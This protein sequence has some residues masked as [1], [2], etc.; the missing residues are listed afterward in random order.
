[1]RKN[2]LM[3]KFKNFT[4]SNWIDWL[5]DMIHVTSGSYQYMD[6][7]SN[8]FNA[9]HFLINNK[10]NPKQ[11]NIALVTVINKTHKIASY[12]FELYQL[13]DFT[14]YSKPESEIAVL[15]RLLFSNE[16][17]GLEY[18]NK[19]LHDVLINAL[20]T[21][22]NIDHIKF[23]NLF[24]KGL[25]TIVSPS[26]ILAALRYYSKQYQRKGYYY[27]IEEVFKVYE[28]HP[29]YYE[30]VDNVVYS[31]IEMTESVAN[32]DEVFYWIAEKMPVWEEMSPNCLKALVG[33]SRD[34]LH[35][36]NIELKSFPYARLLSTVFNCT[37]IDDNNTPD[38]NDIESLITA[39]TDKKIDTNST[40]IVTF[41]SKILI[42]LI[43]IDEVYLEQLDE[44][45]GKI[46]RYSKI[47]KEQ[48]Y[49]VIALNNRVRLRVSNMVAKDRKLRVA[50]S[51]RLKKVIN[52]K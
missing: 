19:S 10:I 22:V 43:Y 37:V 32:Y 5:D 21:F 26:F 15:E 11:F 2:D 51:N 25:T 24:I 14:A 9:Y 27:F 3:E 17:L 49:N 4:V 23:D 28:L 47:N 41:V 18:D 29:E 40:F 45:S 42:K 31:I 48:K 38:K 35:V 44:I 7:S 12:S 6:I 52:E 8:L 30:Y 34:W 1:M 16:L 50:V 33:I 39:C 13:I 46:V 20:C 36:D